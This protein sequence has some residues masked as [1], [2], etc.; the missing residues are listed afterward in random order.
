MLI[1]Q[2]FLLILSLLATCFVS[3]QTHTCGTIDYL[4]QRISEDPSIILL[5]ENYEQEI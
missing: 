2:R 3:A 5:R 1:V 4:E